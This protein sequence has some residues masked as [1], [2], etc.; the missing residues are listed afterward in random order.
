MAEKTKRAAETESFLNGKKWERE[1]VEKAMQ[2]V[3]KDF[4]PISDARAGKDFRTV[5]ARNLLMKYFLYTEEVGN[6]KH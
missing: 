5:A 3:E 4:T 2:Y 6:F 1:N